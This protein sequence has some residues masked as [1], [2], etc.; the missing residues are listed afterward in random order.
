MGLMWA[1]RIEIGV[2]QR[3]SDFQTSIRTYPYGLPPVDQLCIMH[4]VT[5]PCHQTKHQRL[6]K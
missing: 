1:F 4:A 3:F 5:T 2:A 6:L